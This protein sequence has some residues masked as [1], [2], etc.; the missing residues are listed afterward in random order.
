MKKKKLYRRIPP[1]PFNLTFVRGQIGK[2]YV[3][4]HYSY[5]AIRTK[6]PDMTRIVTSIEQRKC[7]DLFAEAVAYAKEVIANVK[8]K[9]AWQ[10][11]L[12]RPNGV[13]NE[14]VKT[15]MLREKR[16][17]IHDKMIAETLLWKA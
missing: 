2:Q 7:R 15:Y 4:K 1:L 9:E 3:I 12:R 13:Y 10:K 5:G 17:A 6:Y 16:K 11:R 8:L 14:A